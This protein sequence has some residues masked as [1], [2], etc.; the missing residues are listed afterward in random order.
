MD[1]HSSVSELFPS[2]FSQL[3]DQETSVFVGRRFIFLQ[4][5]LKFF[6]VQACLHK[7]NVTPVRFLSLDHMI[8]ILL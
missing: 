3:N 8:K 6:R 5:L 4:Y 7:K 1:L 2:F